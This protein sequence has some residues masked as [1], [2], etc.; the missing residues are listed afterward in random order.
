MHH[1][2]AEIQRVG[3]VADRDRRGPRPRSCPR[4]RHRCRRGRSS[5]WSC[6]R[7]SRR[8]GRGCRRRSASGRRRRQACTAPKRFEMPRMAT[9]GGERRS[10]P[11]CGEGLGEGSGKSTGE[12]AARGHARRYPSPQPLPARGRGAV[13]RLLRNR[14][15]L[16]HRHAEIAAQDRR[17]LLLDHLHHVGRQLRL[18]VMERR[19]RGAALGH[20]GE[21]AE[22]RAV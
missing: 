20:G 17:F 22:I 13:A 5:G 2:D 7:R 10:P 18:P 3:G 8:A 11:P 16:V 4:R 1:A 21:A 14:R 15:A 9:R 6:R 19:E 12:D